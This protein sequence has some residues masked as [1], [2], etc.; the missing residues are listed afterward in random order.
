MKVCTRCRKPK[1]LSDF[2]VNTELPDGRHRCCRECMNQ[3]Q[4]DRREK[5]KSKDWDYFQ[6]NIDAGLERL[7]A[8]ARRGV[9]LSQTE[10]ALECNCTS[11]AIREIEIGALKKVRAIIKRQGLSHEAKDHISA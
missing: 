6:N 1:P 10:I 7:Y 11:E 4:Q 9:P 5:I 2:N 8:I 3:Y